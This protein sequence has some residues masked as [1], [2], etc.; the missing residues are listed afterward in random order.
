MF[1]PQPAVA[2]SI[3]EGGWP[4]RTILNFRC[5]TVVAIR[6]LQWEGFPLPPDISLFPPLP[7]VVDALNQLTT[8][9]E[10][11]RFNRRRRVS[12]ADG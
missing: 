5:R 9:V 6:G 7:D 1:P 2:V 8:P 11:N 3:R 4:S 10:E 12:T